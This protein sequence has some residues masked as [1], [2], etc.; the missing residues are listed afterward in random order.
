MNVQMR[1]VFLLPVLA[2]G[3]GFL[4][5]S[6][7]NRPEEIVRAG[8]TADDGP[9][10]WEMSDPSGWRVEADGAEATFAADPHYALF[11]DA[12][13]RLDYRKTG[14]A[15]G[16]AGIRRPVG[17]GEADGFF[18]GAGFSADQADG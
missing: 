12:T 8:R 3:V 6:A 1:R 5:A 17:P 2:S 10:D 18:V 14:E 7:G 16:M 13:C 11:A 15:A 4:P 9:M